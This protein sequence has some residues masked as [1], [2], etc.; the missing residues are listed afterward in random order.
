MLEPVLAK[1]GQA[2]AD[3]AVRGWLAAR[4]AKAER[5][6]ELKDLIRSSFRDQVAAP[7]KF[8]NQVDGIALAVEERLRPLAEQEFGGLDEAARAAVVLEVTAA[9]AEADLSDEAVFVADADPLRVAERIV[10]ALPPRRLGT[11]ED[12]LYEV[13]LA[14]AVEC[15]VRMMQQLPLYLPR[16]STET[17][18]RVSGLTQLAEQTLAR[19]PRRTLDAPEGEQDDAAFERRYLDFVS[20][21]LD[22]VELLG[23]RVES[24]RPRTSLSLSYIS[25]SVSS[26]GRARR[27]AAERLPLDSITASAAAEPGTQRVEA[28]LGRARRTLVR[29]D[30]GSGKSTLLRWL[31]VTAARGAFTGEL[32]EWNGCV[33]LLVK[34]RSHGDGVLPAP[35]ELLDDVAREVAGRMPRGWVER[36]LDSGR[37]LLLVDGVDELVP[38]HRGTVRHWV[39]R[40]LVAYPSMR[41]IVTSRATAADERWLADG[42]FSAALL[43]PMTPADLRELI[44][45]W[46]V[47]M[48]ECPSLPCAPDE[49][50]GFEGALL[51]GLESR[52]H[53]RALAVTPLLAAMLCALN[54]DRRRQ[55]PR[56]RMELYRAVLDM[57]LERRDSERKIEDTVDLDL[58]QKVWILRD[59]AWRLV[60]TGRAELSKAT[61]LRRIEQRLADMTRM[62]YGAADVLD[63]LLRRSGVLREP[64]DGRIDFAHRTLQEYL[65]AAQL[66]EDDDVDAAVEK[67]HLDQW[68]EVVVMAAGHATGRVRRELI[69]GLLARAVGPGARRMRLLVAACVETMQAIPAEVRDEV[70]ACLRAAIPPR[71]EDEARALAAL[72]RDA[73]DRLPTDLSGMT[74]RQAARCVRTVWRINGPEAL[75]RLAGYASDPRWHV[76]DALDDGWQYFDA[77]TYARTVLAPAGALQVTVRSERQLRALRHLPRAT[78]VTA[79]DLGPEVDLSPLAGLRDLESLLLGSR[80]APA[81]GPIRGLDRLEWLTV[82][83]D[84][85]HTEDVRVL[86]GLPALTSLDYLVPDLPDLLFLDD[87]PR[88]ERLHLTLSE[89]DPAPIARQTELRRLSLE[90]NGRPFVPFEHPGLTSL[91]LW[92][93]T[94][95]HGGYHALAA[96][97]P[98]L[99]SLFLRTE[100]RPTDLSPLDSLDLRRIN[101]RSGSTGGIGALTSLEEVVLL[102]VN[103]LD[104]QEVAGLPR[105]RH[106]LLFHC[107]V[108][109]LAPLADRSGLLVELVE[110]GKVGNAELLRGRNKVLIH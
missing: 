28:A 88:L 69:A 67:A 35:A 4:G 37:G 92:F 5:G 14:E 87:L 61:A 105:L 63:H 56:S 98:S 64:V 17:L 18:Q 43:E 31:A 13:L 9:L 23:V 15:A 50:D 33:P 8:G 97:Y 75:D 36:V 68:R 20:R 66:V 49:L 109:D 46:H 103:G 41:V 53:L 107:P 101:L 86:I 26:G 58:D 52:G 44:H 94:G 93:A 10:A 91:S 81:L 82:S 100:D 27:A 74:G 54:L 34:L 29:G 65:A 84:H 99:R 89:A 55:L 79:R 73:L 57:L 110:C 30:A 7:R 80:R 2:V 48:R 16:L 19:M 42:G 11:A 83:A 12:R 47:A 108:V 38:R 77:D 95:I 104:L 76:R 62:P 59:L 72:G 39:G 24:Y 40:M 96:A 85:A 106:L 90:I 6:A 45:Q 60:S 22:E 71:S 70:E 78:G 32:R 102:N 3:R 21:T 51:A 1:A 25:L